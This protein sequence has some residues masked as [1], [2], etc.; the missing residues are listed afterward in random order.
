MLPDRSGNPV[1]LKLP[2]TPAEVKM[3]VGPIDANGLGAEDG[4]RQR[5]GRRFGG[6]SSFSF[7]R[8]GRSAPGRSSRRYTLGACPDD[9]IPPKTDFVEND[10]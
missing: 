10:A 3:R 6:A 5:S 8:D 2:L 1:C 9:N 7:V 4:N